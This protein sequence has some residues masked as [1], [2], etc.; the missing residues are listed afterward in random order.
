M[1]IIKGL[2]YLC[3]KSHSYFLKDHWH[4]SP[5]DGYLKCSDNKPHREASPDR[6]MQNRPRSSHHHGVG[7]V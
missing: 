6:L 5:M 3:T 2:W 1:K 4:Y 7:F